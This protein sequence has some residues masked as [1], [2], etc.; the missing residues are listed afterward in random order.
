MSAEFDRFSA[1]YEEQMDRS[2]AFGCREHGFYLEAKA[3]ALRELVERRLGTVGETRLLDVGCGLG[4]IHPYLKG[5]GELHGVDPS[6]PTIERA[7]RQNPHV[8]YHVGADEL[9]FDS[10]S[11]DVTTA[12]AVLHHVPPPER[13][14][15]AAE[16]GRVTRPGGLVV[17]FEHN[18]F[19]PGARLVVLRCAFDED[20]VLLRGGETAS[21]LGAA[22]IDALETRYILIFPWK[23]RPLARIEQALAR[24]PIGAQYYVAG[25]AGR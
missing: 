4:L 25:V 14:A 10:G 23:A 12:M 24:L 17:I 9:P 21:L 15:F 11:Y 7:R 13:A 2:I 1:D 22:G 20:V 8:E 6:V 16:L 3:A 18:P 19:N 5:F